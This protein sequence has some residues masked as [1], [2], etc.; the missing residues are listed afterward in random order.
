[1]ILSHGELDNSMT[2]TN[3]SASDGR[4]QLFCSVADRAP[5]FGHWGSP[6]SLR[7]RASS[8]VVSR[9]GGITHFLERTSIICVII[10]G[11]TTYV[12]VFNIA[13]LVISTI[14]IVIIHLLTICIF[15]FFS[16]LMIDIS[17]LVFQIRLDNLLGCP[18]MGELSQVWLTFM[19][20]DTG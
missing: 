16:G 6:R 1:M 2:A 13:V 8:A 17:T 4:R 3:E 20:L 9:K 10:T 11:C 7:N 18:V 14:L 12:Y 15:G 19:C 5:P